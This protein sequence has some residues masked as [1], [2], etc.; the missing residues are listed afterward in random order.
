MYQKFGNI[1][2][3]NYFL[4]NTFGRGT[5]QQGNIAPIYWYIKYA[6][7]Y[8]TPITIL[9]PLILFNFKKIFNKQTIF[10][11]VWSMLIFIPFSISKSKVWWYIFPFWIPSITLLSL[12]LE[13]LFKNKKLLFLFILLT[14]LFINFQTHKQS[15]TRGNYNQGIKNLA[16]TNPNITSLAVYQLPYESPLFYFDTGKIYRNFDTDTEYLLVNIDYLN[17]I[18]LDNWQILDSSLG[19]YLLKRI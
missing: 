7:T 19:V 17:D 4:V 18:N 1:F 15:Q 3:Q 14:T 9:F 5:G 6:L 16:Q 8:W 10:L 11:L 13:N 12:S 2:I